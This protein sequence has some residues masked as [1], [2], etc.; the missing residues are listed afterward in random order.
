MSKLI[1]N[2]G[3]PLK[4]NVAISGAKNAALPILAASIMSQN[5]IKLHNVPQKL[6]DIQL[7]LKILQHIGIGYQKNLD[8]I[9]IEKQKI[10]NSHIDSSLTSKMRA[11]IVLLGPLLAKHGH[12]SI[13][14]PGGCIIGKRPIDLHLTA[15][16]ALGANISVKDGHIHASCNDRLQGTSFSFPQITV[17]GTANMLMAA[18]L[19][20]GKT[21]IHNAALEPEITDLANFLNCLGAKIHGIGS[22]TLTIDGVNSL[23]NK[24]NYAI[25]PDRIE[26]GTYLIAAIV[27]RGKLLLTNTE[28]KIMQK[29]LSQ[30][31]LTGIKLEYDENSIFVDATEI[32]QLKAVNISTEPYPGFPTDLQ[33][34][35]AVINTLS[36]NQASTINENIFENRFHYVE[37]LQ[38]MGA[39]IEIQQ[40]HAQCLG[41]KTLHGAQVVA[42]DLRAAACLI[43]AALATKGMTC[44]QQIEHAYRGYEELEKK[45]AAIGASILYEK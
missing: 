5:Q 8:N 26:A 32:K 14:F 21:I 22:N 1:I 35:F 39:Q 17:T 27:T 29:V 4:G 2:G 42:R 44:I 30:L 24:T 3:V 20:K 23:N 19:A 15:L 41:V 45:L 16:Q 12:A 36:E 28:P 40:Q 38:K 18:T 9:I 7:M 34:Q 13:A 33:S 10:I 6:L 43:L 31:S 11:S 37:Q 25:I